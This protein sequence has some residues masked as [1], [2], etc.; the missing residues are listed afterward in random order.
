ML[1][2][3]AI[4]NYNQALKEN[5]KAQA[6]KDA[7]TAAAHEAWR[8][9]QPGELREKTNSPA[10]IAAMQASEAEKTARAAANIAEAVTIAASY[11]VLICARNAIYNAVTAAPDQFSKPLHYKVMH[12]KL[13]NICGDGFNVYNSYS[14][15]YL[16][17]HNATGERE[18]FL[19]DTTNENKINFDR[20]FLEKR[21]PELSLK[22]IKKEVKQAAKD[23]EKL[24]KAA[25]ALYNQSETMRNKYKS[26]VRH[27]MPYSRKYSLEDN[28]KLF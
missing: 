14:S 24:R 16:R 25:E 18:I 19:F 13:N 11:N 26:Y 1:V 5:T 12:E 23:A 6:A 27:L 21:D 8:S 9:I 2:N 22:E 20:P 4:K 3:E 17:Y 10:Y 28:Y 7:A 15:V